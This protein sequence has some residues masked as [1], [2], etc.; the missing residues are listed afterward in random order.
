MKKYRA[1][2]PRLAE[3]LEQN[4]PESLTVL[5]LPTGHRRRLRTSNMLERLNEEVNRRTQVAGLFPNEG[6]VLR[7]V[8][9][10]FMEISEDWETGRRYLTMGPG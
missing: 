2:A 1:S 7:L 4:A 5:L 6:S 10:I 3:W 8:S 9:A